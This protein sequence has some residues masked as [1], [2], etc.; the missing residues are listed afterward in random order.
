ML[1][2]LPDEIR[3]ALCEWARDCACIQRLY[4]FGSRARGTARPNSDLDLAVILYEMH[5]NELSELI[6]R[7][8][9]WQ[10]ELTRALGVQVK[11]IDLANDPESVAYAAV[12]DHGILIFD[13][14]KTEVSRGNP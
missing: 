4:V 13:R 1:S 6:V 11:D 14:D 8:K 2:G 3:G 12:R 7:R 5:G 9:N 10:T